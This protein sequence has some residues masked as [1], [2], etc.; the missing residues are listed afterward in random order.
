MLFKYISVIFIFLS[1]GCNC[2][3]ETTKYET[4]NNLLIFC[5]AYR[6]CHYVPFSL[7]NK[8]SSNEW[9][10]S[11]DS[12]K[13]RLEFALLKMNNDSI[14]EIYLF[15]NKTL[16]I[17][18]NKLNKR[19]LNQLDCNRKDIIEHTY[20]D[21]ICANINHFKPFYQNGSYKR[22][23]IKN[24]LLNNEDI[25]NE[26][27]FFLIDSSKQKFKF[28]YTRQNANKLVVRYRDTLLSK[29]YSDS[30]FCLQTKVIFLK[31]KITIHIE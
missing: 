5:K 24:Y 9:V 30:N 31:N 8:N 3:N 26:D 23:K 14:I 18:D 28:I 4:I 11:N 17:Y 21:S 27:L 25:F 12:S 10:L 20:E 15:I 29:L 13:K 16:Y 6:N 7:F 19:T 2:D 1:V 22:L